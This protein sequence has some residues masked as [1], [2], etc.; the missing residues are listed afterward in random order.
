[1]TSLDYSMVGSFINTANK[2]QA[3]GG[4]RVKQNPKEF[5]QIDR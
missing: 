5:C 3:E 2:P 4:P 1:M